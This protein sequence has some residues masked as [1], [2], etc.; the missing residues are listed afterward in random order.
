M[1][2]IL[3]VVA[4]GKSGTYISHVVRCLIIM[5]ENVKSLVGLRH[6]KL[7]F[8]IQE[9][10]FNCSSRIPVDQLIDDMPGVSKNQNLLELF[11]TNKLKTLK[12]SHPLSF[13]ISSIA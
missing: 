5:L 13:I 8:F 12:K 9:A 4:L 2:S 6:E 3:A 11:V 10:T 1:I 7:I